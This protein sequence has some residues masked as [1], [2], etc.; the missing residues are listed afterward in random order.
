M[1]R[2]GGIAKRL[3]WIALILVVV[4]VTGASALLVAVTLRAL[5]QTTGSIAI[6]G[7]D[8]PALVDRD[9]SGIAWIQA[10]TPHDL[11]LAQGYIHAQE[12]MWQMEVWRHISAGRLSE[13][14]GASTLDEDRFIRTLG[15]RQAA[16]RDL[17]AL[18]PDARAAVDAYAQGVNAWLTDHKGSLGLPFVVTGM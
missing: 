1:R 4:L 7:L 6:T 3:V 8:K 9:A 17:D 12:R 18:S 11:F 14:F 5:P 13:L 16:Q 10:D 2:V 15:W